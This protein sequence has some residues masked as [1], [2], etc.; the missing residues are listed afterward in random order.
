MTDPNDPTSQMILRS[1]RTVSIPPGAA[2]D[3][4]VRLLPV[5][6]LENFE[7][8][9]SLGRPT[10]TLG[11]LT[12]ES[13]DGT[14]WVFDLPDGAMDFSLVPAAQSRQFSSEPRYKHGT[15]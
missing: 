13:A 2:Q 10:V 11:V 3:V 1:S 5:I 9:V 4:N 12:V 8:S 15:H 14:Q 7:R 6:Q